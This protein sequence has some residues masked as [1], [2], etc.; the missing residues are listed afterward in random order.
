M[1]LITKIC[2]ECNWKFTSIGYRPYCPPCQTW[3]DSI[4]TDRKRQAM[5][6]TLK[7]LL[8]GRDKDYPPT[9]SMLANAHIL[10]AGV[11]KL[12]AAYG[13]PLYVSSGYRPGIHNS[14]G[15]KSSLH[16]TLQAIDFKDHNR[17]FATWCLANLGLLEAAGLWLESPSHTPTWVHLDTRRRKNRVFLP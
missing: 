4:A 6:V 15:V 17:E 14:I 3:F 9:P 8:M 7:E 13:K 16:M 5:S 10:L 2:R 12:R 1:G 11:N